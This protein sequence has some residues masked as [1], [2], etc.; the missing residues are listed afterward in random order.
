MNHA[1]KKIQVTIAGEVSTNEDDLRYYSTDGGV[2]ELEPTAIV[3]PRDAND[4]AKLV[5]VTAE[6]NSQG[7]D[8][9]SLTARGN[10]TDQGGGPIN[11]GII[12]DFMKH[13]NQILEISE[14]SVLV[15][16]GC[17]YG[18]MQDELIAQGRFIPSYPASIEGLLL[19]TPQG[20]RRSNMV[21]RGGTLRLFK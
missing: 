6:I 16:P 15:Q 20:K 12:V 19:I 2:F 18:R 5:R 3:F 14:D 17:L 21:R 11:T 10:G 1:I 8:K 9:V 13:M 7:G 4:V